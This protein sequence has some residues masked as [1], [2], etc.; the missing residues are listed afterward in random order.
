MVS[1][2]GGIVKHSSLFRHSA[3]TCTYSMDID[4]KHGHGQLDIVETYNWTSSMDMEMKCRHGYGHAA[5]I[6]TWT[7]SM[8]MANWTCSIDMICSM[9]MGGIDMGCSMDI[10]CSMGMDIQHGHG[11]VVWTWNAVLT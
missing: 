1:E 7:C 2:N 4:M 11:H 6:W 5:W 3:L 9:D 10:D 8:D